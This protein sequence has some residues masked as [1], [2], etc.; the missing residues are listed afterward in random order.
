MR[1]ILS[2]ARKSNGRPAALDAP[3]DGWTYALLGELPKPGG[4]HVVFGEHL[5]PE[6]TVTEEALMESDIAAGATFGILARSAVGWEKHHQA[7]LKTIDQ[8]QKLITLLY[9]E[10][11]KLIEEKPEEGGNGLQALLQFA[12]LL[13]LLK[14]GDDKKP[15]AAEEE[16]K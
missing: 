9:S 5:E 12:P 10:R 3:E 2:V 6:E 7:L 11:A 15:A 16:K 13:K 1:Q 8:Q 4:Y 14:S